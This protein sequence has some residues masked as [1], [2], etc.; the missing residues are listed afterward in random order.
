MADTKTPVT[1][2]PK[3]SETPVALHLEETLGTSRILS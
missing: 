1:T 3:Q 2:A